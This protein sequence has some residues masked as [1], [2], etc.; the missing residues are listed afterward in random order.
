MEIDYDD[1]GFKAPLPSSNPYAAKALARKFPINGLVHESHAETL[2]SNKER[3][4]K[5]FNMQNSFMSIANNGQQKKLFGKYVDGTDKQDRLQGLIERV[6]DYT[7]FV[8]MQNLKHHRAE[9]RK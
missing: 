1:D 2:Q 3:K 9:Q 5:E 8:L 6:E 7:R 4:R